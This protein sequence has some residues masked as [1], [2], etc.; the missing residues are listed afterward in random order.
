MRSWR[1]RLLAVLGLAAAAS[2]GCGPDRPPN[3]VLISI[4]T[5][6]PDHL[7]C[8]GYG[9]DTSPEIDRLAA[10]G[11]RFEQ[12]IAHASSTLPSHASMLSSLLPQHHGASYALKRPL[13]ESA[14]TVAEV[15]RGAGYRT[16]SFN[17]GGQI[18]PD[19]GLTQGFEIYDSRQL[20]LDAQVDQALTWIDGLGDAPFFL[21]LHTYDVHHPYEPEPAMLELFADEDYGGELGD[22]ISVELLRDINAGEVEITDA[23][24]AH[25]VSTYDAEIRAM[26]R[27]IGDFLRRLEARRLYDDALVIFTS[28]HGEEF[29]EHGSVG[30]H[31]HSLYDELL[32]VPL[33]LK[34][35]ASEHR[36]TTVGEQVRLIDLAPT[37]LEEAGLPI[38]AQ[39][40][41]LG[42]RRVVEGR[43]DA[44]LPAIS[45]KDTE[46]Q[47]YQSLRLRG[48][49]WVY[50][51][52]FDLERDPGERQDLAAS[53]PETAARLGAELR[54][55]LAETELQAAEPIEL[56]DAAREQL[57][58]LGY[59]D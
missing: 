23:D 56:D 42:L 53:D 47:N 41:G 30:W 18:G 4:D 13:P 3:V 9:R 43:L 38:P 11:I 16:A 58:A 48:R 45:L 49:K 51:S 54:R 10:A 2:A 59:V 33:I 31:S 20:P 29:G 44:P 32:L 46:G 1:H 22:A 39:Y 19:F 12:A 37:I 21:F 26:D 28:D 52:L 35:P 8:Y 50:G 40:A 34:L 55:M 57:E 6:R 14:Q 25:I 36:G 17:G 7:G 15:L 24:L 5:L 27:S